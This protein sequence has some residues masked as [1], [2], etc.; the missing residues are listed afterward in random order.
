VRAL[1]E[2]HVG[3]DFRTSEESAWDVG[4]FVGYTQIVEP[5]TSLRPDDARIVLAGIQV[6]LGE[7]GPGRAPPPPPAEAPAVREPAPKVES[8]HD[9]LA[10]AVDA[11][12]A[13]QVES[14]DD[15]CVATVA[16]DGDRLA[17]GD[18]IHFELDSARIHQVSWGLVRR[19]A[20]FIDEHPEIVEVDI[21]GHADAR[22]TDAYN[23]A[24]SEARAESTRNLL[25][26]YGVDVSR[27]RPIGHGKRRL[28]VPTPY[29]EPRNRRVEFN[30]VIRK[31][32]ATRSAAPGRGTKGEP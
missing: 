14:A 20:S 10:V 9:G 8:D 3:Y 2:A 15:G 23:Q 18:I 16:I 13:G 17:I 31:P 11:C 6:S 28:K 21:E 19:I 12:P 26:A 22:G 32:E 30:V 5:D 25:V 24:L 27:L 29:A 7:R 1:F 4:P